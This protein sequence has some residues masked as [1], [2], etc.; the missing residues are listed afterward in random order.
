ML[1]TRWVVH[2]FS[3]D[4]DGTFLAS[5]ESDD[6]TVVR[7]DLRASRALDVRTYTPAVKALMWAAARGQIE[8]ILGGPP[9]GNEAGS[10]LYR[11]MLLLWLVAHTGAT[12]NSLCSPFF[13][14]EAPSW[15]PVW[16]SFTW[17][18]FKDEFR[19]LRYH[20]VA[21]DNGVF[22]MAST[23][24]ISDGLD[25]TE[26]DIPRLNFPTPSSTW[27]PSLLRGLAGAMV[28]WRRSDLRRQE[29]VMSKIAK[30]KEMNAQELAYWEKHV[31]RGHVPYDRRCQTWSG[32]QQQAEHIG[33]VW[34]RRP[35]RWGWTLQDPSARRASHPVKGG[36][37]TYWLVRIAIHASSLRW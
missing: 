29:I 25:I 5:A 20:S 37:A 34:H 15:H 26:G 35:T 16:T 17:S 21:T 8:G 33:A 18:R 31:S 14:M 30:S 4:E 19:Y 24:P 13:M 28:Q 23:L 27:P 7:I 3:G 12:A 36:F 2:L 9:R 11:R 22:F 6:V 10:M 32:Q 1:R